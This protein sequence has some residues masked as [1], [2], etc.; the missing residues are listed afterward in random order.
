MQKNKNKLIKKQD[1][2][3]MKNEKQQRYTPE[4]ISKNIQNV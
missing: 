1:K 4:I 3:N 2:Y